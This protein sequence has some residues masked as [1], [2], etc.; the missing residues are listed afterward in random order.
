MFRLLA[1]G[2]EQAKTMCFADHGIARPAH[3]HRDLRVRHPL[4]NEIP[5]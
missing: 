2:N 1:A 5:L 3:R 4:L